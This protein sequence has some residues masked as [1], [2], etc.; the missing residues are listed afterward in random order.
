[1]KPSTTFA[2]PIYHGVPAWQPAQYI[3]VTDPIRKV[4]VL[5][6][7]KISGYE[8][9]FKLLRAYSPK[10]VTD[11][12]IRASL[13]YSAPRVYEQWLKSGYWDVK[14]PKAEG[15]FVY[16]LRQPKIDLGGGIKTRAGRTVQDVFRVQKELIEKDKLRYVLELREQKTFLL[17]QKGLRVG[18]KG[19]GGQ[20]GMQL[21]SVSD[22]MKGYEVLKD[23]QI[24]SIIFKEGTYKELQSIARDQ[25]GLYVSPMKAGGLR[26]RLTPT[27]PAQYGRTILFDKTVDV[28]GSSI[29]QKA[30]ITK[31]PWSRTFAPD[32]VDETPTVTKLDSASRIHSQQIIQQLKGSLDIS[33]QARITQVGKQIFRTPQMTTTGLDLGLMIQLGLKTRTQLKTDLKQ[34]QGLKAMLKSQQLIKQANLLKQSTALKTALKTQTVTLTAPITPFSPALKTPTFKMPPITTTPTWKPPVLFPTEKKLKQRIKRFK[35][36]D[37]NLFGTMPDF[38]A[39][40]LGLSPKEVGGV[41]DAMKEIR[42]IQTGFGIRRGARFKDSSPRQT[43]GM[44]FSSGNFQE[45]QL[46]RGIM[47]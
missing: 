39:R 33:P 28:R 40:A 21:V 10:E 37:I 24:K 34:D 46:L 19:F 20:K 31:T 27:D 43:K 29:I 16:E 45:K 9:A 41:D 26:I 38:T 8:K 14:Y 1:V 32:R 11:A 18:V 5:V 17:D 2:Q 12:S 36:K 42:K 47:I 23:P 22:T 4:S 6:K 30:K 15:K 35:M 7:T 44:R 3:K 13:R 25:A